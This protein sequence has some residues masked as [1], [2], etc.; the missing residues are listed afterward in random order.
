ME[1]NLIRTHK[2]DHATTGILNIAGNFQC[3]ICEDQVRAPGVKVTGKTAIPAGR[4]EVTITFSQRFQRR[5]P[6]LMNVPMFEGIR[7]HP[8][9]TELDT[10]GCLLPG[11]TRDVKAGTVGN[12]VASF[13]EL[14]EK[15]DKALHV[16]KVFIT[17]E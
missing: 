2:I 8:G 12:S 7:I 5:L 11:R 14:F 15:I 17:I 1:L 16:E 4:Y 9:N 13:N 6:L 3:F 10:E